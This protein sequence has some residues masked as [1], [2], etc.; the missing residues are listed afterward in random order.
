MN[1]NLDSLDENLLT[2]VL[3]GKEIAEDLNTLAR[4]FKKGNY[5]RRA[6]KLKDC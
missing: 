2:K 1:K 6:L 3:E 4:D 5:S